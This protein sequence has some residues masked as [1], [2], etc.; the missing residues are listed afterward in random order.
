[1]TF[2]IRW[3]LFKNYA[4]VSQ[5]QAPFSN[6]AYTR[7][8]P[9]S[10]NRNISRKIEKD[11]QH[12]TIEIST[13]DQNSR[14]TQGMQQP[15]VIRKQSVPFQLTKHYPQCVLLTGVTGF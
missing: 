15:K 2:C 12:R 13:N 10:N 11:R 4:D 9:V 1:M 7:F 3:S 5:T 6:I 8:F 14:E